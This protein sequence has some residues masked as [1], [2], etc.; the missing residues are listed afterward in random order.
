MIQIKKEHTMQLLLAQA[1]AAAGL[2][3][4]FVIKD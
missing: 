2:Q 4:N 3:K 1:P